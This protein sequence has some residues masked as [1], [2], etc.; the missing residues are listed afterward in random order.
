MISNKIMKVY[1]NEN[2][3]MYRA[4]CDCSSVDCDLVLDIEHDS[5]LNMIFINFYK[6]LSWSSYKHP[7]NSIMN[8]LYRIKYACKILFTGSIKVECEFL[9]K[10]DSVKDFIIALEEAKTKL[11]K[12]PTTYFG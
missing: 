5:E 3:I 12:S 2:A 8:L 7:H 6:N 11:E 9:M 4:M 1:E 10:G